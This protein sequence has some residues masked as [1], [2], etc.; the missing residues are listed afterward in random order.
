A[1]SVVSADEAS[2]R[3][4]R[5]VLIAPLLTPA[6]S[7]ERQFAAA[8]TAARTSAPSEQ[9]LPELTGRRCADS[10]AS[11]RLPHSDR[12]ALSTHARRA[13][14]PPWEEG[15]RSAALWPDAQLVSTEGL[16][17]NRMVDHASVIDQAL[18]FVGPAS[19]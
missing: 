11:E 8:G 4:A 10:D 1:P 7:A 13:R 12:P 6:K 9:W 5:N 18:H 2:W 17:H 14:E 16:G 15:A 19:R 3:P